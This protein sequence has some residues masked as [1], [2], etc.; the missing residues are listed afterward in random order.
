MQDTSR[1][2]DHAQAR[3]DELRDEGIDLTPAEIVRINALAWGIESPESRLTTSKGDPVYVGGVI[4]WPQTIH[5]YDWHCKVAK[6]MPTVW[7]GRIALAYSMAHGYSDDGKLDVY[8]WRAVAA[9]TAWGARLR[10]RMD[11]LIEAMSQIIQQDEEEPVP[12]SENNERGSLGQISSKISAITGLTPETVERKMS[13]KHAVAIACRAGEQLKTD[14]ESNKSA[15][16]QRANTAML[17]YLTEIRKSRS[18]A[19]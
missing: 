18:E 9:V 15:S 19:Q 5:A 6:D 17:M 7:H 12:P 4:L 8:G 16:Y 14:G 2:S 13:M 11:A 10:C 3:I 1:L